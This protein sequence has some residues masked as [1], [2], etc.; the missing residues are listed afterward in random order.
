MAL[1][2]CLV[3]LVLLATSAGATVGKEHRIR[4]TRWTWSFLSVGQLGVVESFSRFF[5]M[6]DDEER[7]RELARLRSEN[8]VLREEKARLIGVLQENERLR[9]LVGFKKLH[10]EYELV[11]A[12]VVA[13]D[14]SPFFRVVSIRIQPPH[15]VKLRPRQPVLVAG[16]VVGQIHEVHDDHAQVLLLSD[17]RSQIDVISQRNR[18][19]GIVSGLGHERD[20]EA[21]VS[22]LSEKD[23]IRTGDVM[24][25]SGMGGGFPPE[26]IVGEVLSVTP[27]ERGLF[28][29][30]VLEPSVDLARVEEVFVL[31]GVKEQ[32]LSN[33]EAPG[34][35]GAKGSLQGVDS[36]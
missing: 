14:T 18:A 32:F 17:P 34:E 16:G 36:P 29:H 26:L 27:D 20:Y 19:H 22:Y 3:P 33:E 4:P 5:S 28:Q 23:H 11:P 8:A 9:E 25:T 6:F 7:A 12:R 13:Q 35:Q 2:L 1:V 10:P 30:V 31:T 21:K 24:V 15:D